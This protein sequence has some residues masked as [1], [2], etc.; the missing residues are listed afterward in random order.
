MPRTR[1]PRQWREILDAFDRCGLSQAEFC[2][3]RSIVLATFR[4]HRARASTS[5]VSPEAPRLVELFAESVPAPA[6]DL[7]LDLHLPIGP[8][9]V[10]GQPPALAELLGLLASCSTAPRA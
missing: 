3:R 1:T 9:A 6:G 10:H 7:R 2:R 8:L 4:Y 5:P